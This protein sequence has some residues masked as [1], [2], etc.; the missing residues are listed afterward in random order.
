MIGCLFFLT[1]DQIYCCAS[2]PV[3]NHLSPSQLL[4]CR[5]GRSAFSK[6]ERVSRTDAAIQ[7]A[8]KGDKVQTGSGHE[9]NAT[10]C[11]LQVFRS[12]E[13]NQ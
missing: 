5:R 9:S 8:L 13:E 3:F 1:Q 4:R 10:R 2:S 12:P 11:H 6:K 7:F